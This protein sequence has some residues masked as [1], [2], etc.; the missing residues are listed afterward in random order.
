MSTDPHC[1]YTHYESPPKKY[2]TNFVDDPH[3]AGYPKMNKHKLREHFPKNGY[4]RYIRNLRDCPTKKQIERRSR[5][6]K[7]RQKK[8]PDVATLDMK[9]NRSYSASSG[10]PRS[11]AD[12]KLGMNCINRSGVQQNTTSMFHLQFKKKKEEV[13][14][15]E[16]DRVPCE[17]HRGFR[18]PILDQRNPYVLHNCKRPLTNLSPYLKETRNISDEEEQKIIE[19]ISSF[20]RKVNTWD[21]YEEERF[22]RFLEVQD[23]EFRLKLLYC[24][25]EHIQEINLVESFFIRYKD[26]FV[27]KRSKSQVVRRSKTQKEKNKDARAKVMST[28]LKFERD[29][30]RKHP[31]EETKDDNLAQNSK[32]VSSKDLPTSKL[33]KK[34][35]KLLEQSSCKISTKPAKGVRIVSPHL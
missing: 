30:L 23:P 7:E 21:N 33:K 10:A 20:E 17:V 12:L 3:I 9:L 24:M 29:Y 6:T 22:R 32:K 13:P 16:D 35:R 11:M 27:P 8:R 1:A 5:L 31:K 4:K 15:V 2:R 25:R 18:K 28:F 14:E 19:I 34:S 26:T